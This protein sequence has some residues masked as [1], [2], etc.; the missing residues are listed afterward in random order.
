MIVIILLNTDCK[1]FKVNFQLQHVLCI[2]PPNLK[3]V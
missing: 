3:T 2:N 1:I